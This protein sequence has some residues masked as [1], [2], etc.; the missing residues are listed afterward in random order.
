VTAEAD[1]IYGHRVPRKLPVFGE[2]HVIRLDVDAEDVRP[3]VADVVVELDGRLGGVRHVAFPAADFTAAVDV[4]FAVLRRC[5]LMAV[6]AGNLDG[7]GGPLVRIVAVYAGGVFP[8]G[9]HQKL[10][11]LF[12]VLDEPSLGR[13]LL[14]TASDVALP[15]GGA[16]PVNHRLHFLRP[17]DV[18]RRRTVTG[19]ALNTGKFPGADDA[20]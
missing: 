11:V 14:P 2:H 1:K 4:L 5:F 3:H 7:G 20:L 6:G 9:G 12:V 16:R 10:V 13:Y 17:G 19:L 15:A 8:V 18:S